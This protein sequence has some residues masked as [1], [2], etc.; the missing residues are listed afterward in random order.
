[1]G[2][3]VAACLNFRQPFYYIKERPSQLLTGDDKE[4]NSAHV[5]WSNL[6]KGFGLDFPIHGEQR[7]TGLSHRV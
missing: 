1:M 4:L 5:A 3:F 2:P 6:L 7:H